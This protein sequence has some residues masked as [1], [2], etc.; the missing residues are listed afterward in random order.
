MPNGPTERCFSLGLSKIPV[1]NQTTS[2]VGHRWWLLRR[3]LGDLQRLGRGA[4]ELRRHLRSWHA[5]LF[6]HSWILRLVVFFWFCLFDLILLLV[7]F[8]WCFCVNFCWFVWLRLLQLHCEAALIKEL[9]KFSGSSKGI[10]YWN[11]CNLG[12]SILW[13]WVKTPQA[14]PQNAFGKV[15]LWLPKDLRSQLWP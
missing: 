10:C 8:G 13:P 4:Q 11:F 15:A 6:F 7:F 12:V 14:P 5:G 1:A 3:L 9:P 2:L